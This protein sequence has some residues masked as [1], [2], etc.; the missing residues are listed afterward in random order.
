[1][2]RRIREEYSVTELKPCDCESDNDTSEMRISHAWMGHYKYDV[3]VIYCLKCGELEAVKHEPFRYDHSEFTQM[4]YEKWNK[5]N[6]LGKLLIK[7]KETLTAY[8]NN[9][10]MGM[11]ADEAIAA[12]D[13]Y[14]GEKVWLT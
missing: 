1:M 7:T 14:L 4:M 13:E 5:R 6:D 8:S 10:M 3:T 2:S 12:I 11:G 9:D